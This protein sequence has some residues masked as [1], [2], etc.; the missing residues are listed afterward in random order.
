[1]LIVVVFVV[2]AHCVSVKEWYKHRKDLLFERESDK[3]TGHVTEHFYPGRP[4]AIK[5]H[6]PFI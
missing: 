2:G 6:P 5:G 1:M 3:T 4:S